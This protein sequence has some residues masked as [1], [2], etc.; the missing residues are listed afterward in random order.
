MILNSINPTNLGGGREEPAPRTP[1]KGDVFCCF[2]LK[3]YFF[4]NKSKK[5]ESVSLL[6]RYGGLGAR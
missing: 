3:K 2:Y 6:P 5:F 1:P 4:A